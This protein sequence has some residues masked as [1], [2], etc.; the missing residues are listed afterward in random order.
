M[1]IFEI[2]VPVAESNQ[3]RQEEMRKLLKKR[4]KKLDGSIVMALYSGITL[5]GGYLSNG[6]TD[7]S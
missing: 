3:Q 4:G 1:T 6:H 2:A 5:G 7:L